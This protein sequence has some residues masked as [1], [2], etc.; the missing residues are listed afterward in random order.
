MQTEMRREDENV[1]RGEFGAYG[2]K[3]LGVREIA[4]ETSPKPAYW[5]VPEDY[6]YARR[7]SAFVSDRS[8]KRCVE[9]LFLRM[10]A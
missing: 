9:N 4:E 10:T 5:D 1:S 8:V 6:K 2:G 7:Y 3:L